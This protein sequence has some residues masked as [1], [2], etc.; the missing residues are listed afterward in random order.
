MYE[1]LRETKKRYCLLLIGN[2][3]NINS[4]GPWH[5]ATIRLLYMGNTMSYCIDDPFTQLSPIHETFF[6]PN[7]IG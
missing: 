6:K 5:L 3:P 4:P 2:S 7:P 1:I